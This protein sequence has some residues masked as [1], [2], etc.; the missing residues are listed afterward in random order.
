[1]V[2]D[3]GADRRVERARFPRK[4][5]HRHDSQAPR[6]GRSLRRALVPARAARRAAGDRLAS[7]SSRSRTSRSTRRI[8][9]TTAWASRR[10]ST[11]PTATRS[12]VFGT[13]SSTGRASRAGS[14]TRCRADSRRWP[15]ANPHN[16][17][18]AT[19]LCGIRT[20]PG[21]SATPIANSTAGGSTSRRWGC[22]GCG[23]RCSRIPRGSSTTIIPKANKSAPRSSPRSR[24]RTAASG[25][26]LGSASRTSR[27]SR[28][29]DSWER[30]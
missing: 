11:I 23:A 28:R 17:R 12:L 4:R 20:R 10:P 27:S 14:W 16:T 9:P 30:F 1:M 5:G 22:P 26:S 7:R 21:S 24:P 2:I 15:G 3:T 8:P 29:F 6:G 13:A 18:R 25:G 19:R